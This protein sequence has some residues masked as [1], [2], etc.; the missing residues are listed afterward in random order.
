MKELFG[1]IL[2]AVG[3]LIALASGIC[4]LGL[5]V[6]G[7]SYGGFIQGLPLAVIFGGIPF[8]IGVGL[9]SIGRRLAR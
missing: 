2:M 4:S 8:A 9:F 1:G 5:F 3:I 7:S 6:A